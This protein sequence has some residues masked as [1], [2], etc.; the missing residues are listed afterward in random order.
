MCSTLRQHIQLQVNSHSNS[1]HG[2][3]VALVDR[4]PSSTVRELKEELSKHLDGLGP[5][6][7]K[8]SHVKHG[9]LKDDLTLA[10]YNF[11]KGENLMAAAKE[12]G[13]KK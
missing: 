3:S 9:V 4:G 8:L 7:I 2:Q 1:F 13:G 6:K 12:R 10:H 5:N 11:K